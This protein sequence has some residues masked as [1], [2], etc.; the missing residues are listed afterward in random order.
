[1]TR[2]GDFKLG[3]VFLLLGFASALLGI[4]MGHLLGKFFAFSSAAAFLGIAGA[5]MFSCPRIFGKNRSGGLVAASYVVF[6]PFHILNH[7]SLALFR[8]SGKSALFD[9]VLP[10]LFLGSRLCWRDESRF[11]KL[12]ACAVLDLTSEFGEVGFLRKA[13][14]Y[15]CIP[16]LDRT[17]PSF[18][19][20]EAAIG[21]IREQLLRG[22]I[23]VHC[24]LGHGRSATVVVAYL[25]A[26]GKFANIDEALAHIQSKRP[27]VGLNTSQSRALR[28]F[29][30]WM[31]KSSTS[32]MSATR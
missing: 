30:L 14:A 2:Q 25:V 5:Y 19:E 29:I 9:E 3:C 7:L 32:S 22:T 8:W 11:G 26:T 18:A 27:G 1:M 4:I 13:P 20:F 15:L 17:A 21:F 24:A 10:G 23:Y 6:W 31:K 12:N 16:L 28:G